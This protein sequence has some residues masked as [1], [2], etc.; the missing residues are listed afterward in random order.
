MQKLILPFATI[1][2]L[3]I[4]FGFVKY[5]AIN[6]L[7]AE[8]TEFVDMKVTLQF[9]IN[10]L[11][12]GANYSIYHYLQKY[13]STGFLSMYSLL[14]LVSL[15]LYLIGFLPIVYWMAMLYI[16]IRLYAVMLTW[17]SSF[18]LFAFTIP[19]INFIVAIYILETSL[20]LIIGMAILIVFFLFN[21]KVLIDK[22]I[23]SS[24]LMFDVIKSD[25]LMLFGL[26]LIVSYFSVVLIN[27]LSIKTSGISLPFSYQ[28]FAVSSIVIGVV[29]TYLTPKIY[30][31][32]KRA[33]KINF[34]INLSTVLFC[35]LI[36][37]FTKPF[38]ITVLYTADQID[39]ASDSILIFFTL[40]LQLIWQP[41]L[42]SLSAKRYYKL[43]Y[44]CLLFLLVATY[45][46]TLFNVEYLTLL[47]LICCY[48]IIFSLV[49]YLYD[50][51]K[52]DAQPS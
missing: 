19:L 23:I 24:K 39:H 13:T 14:M 40:S 12:F 50:L 46:L 17:D 45:L 2:N 7:I 15:V 52:S 5:L 21:W 18:L 44:T 51:R 30:R 43:S 26:G 48:H 28:L 4:S 31:N 34:I 37:Y 38:L 41:L 27:Y 36:F 32:D 10:L 3:L 29:T 49:I 33:L 42:S 35:G 11:F 8:T 25:G 9:Y 47:L 1:V 16:C 22:P 6:G 20:V